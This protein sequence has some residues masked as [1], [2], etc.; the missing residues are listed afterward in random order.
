[1]KNGLCDILVTFTIISLTVNSSILSFLSTKQQNNRCITEYE[2]T[3]LYE[4]TRN[5]EILLLRLLLEYMFHSSGKML[6]PGIDVQHWNTVQQLVGILRSGRLTTDLAETVCCFT[7][8]W[9][10][11]L[12][13]GTGDTQHL[14]LHLY[15]TAVVH[16]TESISMV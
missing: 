6:Y 5:N 13:T 9:K 15:K 4:W 12:W 3:Q 7:K 2:E 16:E 14:P 1:M 8:P 10:G 11:G